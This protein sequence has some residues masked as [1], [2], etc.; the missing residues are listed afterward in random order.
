[1]VTK[2]KSGNPD[3]KVFSIP[4]AMD[5]KMKQAIDERSKDLGI[6]AQGFI[7]MSIK[8]FLKNGANIPGDITCEV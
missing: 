5:Y 7:R 4:V 2:V 3:A 1:M 6:S 8:N